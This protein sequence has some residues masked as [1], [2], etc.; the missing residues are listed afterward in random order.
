MSTSPNHF[1]FAVLAIL[2]MVLAGTAWLS[3]K[4]RWFWADVGQQAH[5]PAVNISRSG[6]MVY[7]T[8]LGGWDSSFVDHLLIGGECLPAEK[9]RPTAVGQR[10]GIMLPRNSTVSVWA[11]DKAIQ[12]YTLLQSVTI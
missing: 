7:V 6:E 10:V 4:D 3:T 8:W 12:N 1:Y 5:A 2:L 11:F 9:Y